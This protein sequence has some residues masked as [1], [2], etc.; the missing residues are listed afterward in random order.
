MVNAIQEEIGYDEW[1]TMTPESFRR[2][3][4]WKIETFQR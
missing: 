3:A 4:L 2:D 1:L